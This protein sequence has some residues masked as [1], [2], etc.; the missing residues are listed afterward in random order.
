L[1]APLLAQAAPLEPGDHALT[2][3]HDRRERHYI[4]HVPP[5]PKQ[6]A[7]VILNFHGG[8][9]HAAAQ[10]EYSRMDTLADREGFLVV[11]PDGT[12]SFNLL[13]WNAGPGC[14]G[15]AS[16]NNV[17]DVGFTAALIE[18]LAAHIPIDA[19]RVYATD[20]SN[21]A[22]MAYRLAAELPNRIAAIAPVAGAMVLPGKIP[23]AVPVLHI[24]SVDDP[25]A[26]YEGGLGPAFPMTNTRVQHPAVSETLARWS[27]ANGCRGA[28]R[29]A[30]ERKGTAASAGHTATRFVYEGCAAALEH[31]K[32]TGAGHVWPGGKLK[33]LSRLLG[34]GTDVIDANV[35]MWRFFS[36]VAAP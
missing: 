8:G 32:L 15:Y 30:E 13:T 5:Q 27:A 17:D 4:V 14:C 28:P 29:V 31:W 2:L 3:E 11:Y 21:G 23:H 10:Q 26:L 18:D 33:Y 35:E 36:R 6:P 9:G 20:L 12:G 7:P 22:M 25:R 19:K 24:H 1:L 34:P 16:K